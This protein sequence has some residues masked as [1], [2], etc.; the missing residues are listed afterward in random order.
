MT[1]EKELAI[2]LY[3]ILVISSALVP[4][5]LL[6]LLPPKV[7][8]DIASA[9]AVQQIPVDGW[10]WALS[11]DTSTV[12]TLGST[13]QVDSSGTLQF[14]SPTVG[15]PSGPG[16]AAL[17]NTTSSPR[18]VYPGMD[19]TSPVNYGLTFYMT[20]SAT[21]EGYFEGYMW[22]PILGW[23]EFKSSATGCPS[24]PCNATVTSDGFVHGWA[25][26]VSIRDAG[27]DNP[28]PVNPGD[29][30][31]CGDA[32]GPGLIPGD[33]F[34]GWIKLGDPSNWGSDSLRIR[35]DGTLAGF[36]WSD[37][38]GWFEFSGRV[39]NPAG[40]VATCNLNANPPRVSVRRTQPNATSTI[41]WTCVNTNNDCVLTATAT[42]TYTYPG[43]VATTSPGILVTLRNTTR[44]KVTCTSAVP[45]VGSQVDSSDLVTVK[46]PAQ[47]CEVNPND[48]HCY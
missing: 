41:A 23:I 25:R 48:P 13:M 34:K 18:H 17:I 1:P 38:Y 45:P 39:G 7:G 31:L 2:K 36:A 20:N 32:G 44:Y 5:L 43:T 47:I 24:S 12:P 22:S 37:E 9:Q 4:V 33:C 21:G 42:S 29:P 40:A 8:L 27:A 11:T 3:F 26:I 10:A 19:V 16:W 46:F 30:P 35:G 14:T 15:N 28:P 6:L